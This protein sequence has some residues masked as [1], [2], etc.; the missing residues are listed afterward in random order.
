MLNL[1]EIVEKT[2]VFIYNIYNANFGA[3]Y[4]SKQQTNYK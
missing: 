3:Y 1:S 4:G 2:Y